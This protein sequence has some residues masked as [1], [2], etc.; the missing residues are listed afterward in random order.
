MNKIYGIDVSHHQGIVDWD[1]VSEWLKSKNNHQNS[2]FAILRVGYSRRD[3][4]GGLVT[5]GQIL[6][7]LSE[8]SRLSIPIGV[9]VYCYDTSPEAA[10]TTMAQALK[11][12]E[13]YKLQYPVVY[14]VEYGTNDGKAYKS[15]SNY[16]YNLTSNKVN[17]TAIIKAAM[18]T[19]ENS[20]YYGMVYCSRNFFTSYTDLSALSAYDKWEAAYTEKDTD[21]VENGIWQYTSSGVVD[22]ISGNVDLDVAYKDYPGIIQPSA[23]KNDVPQ[24]SQVDNTMIFYGRNQ[25]PFLYSRYGYTRGGGKTWHGGIDIVGLDSNIVRMPWY[26]YDNGEAKS[27]SGTVTRSRIVTDK[28][29]KTWEWG[30]YVCVQLD[31][32]QTPDAVNFMYFAHNDSLL[33]KVGDKVK[34]GDALAIMGNSGNAALND[35]PYKHVHFAVRATATGKDLDPSRY[36]GVENAVGIYGEPVGDTVTE[37]VNQADWNADSYIISATGSD[38]EELRSLVERLKLPCTPVSQ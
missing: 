1:R 30:Y 3:G 37:N 27:I 38:K 26:H 24:K 16:Q 5:D 29:N 2:G 13:E 14:D 20:G 11:T 25:I 33:V 6:R 7:N 35:P 12:I 32:N 17:N 9:Y 18:E 21:A 36:H 8:C 23:E 15:E 34:S 4:K 28:S 22:G 31:A 19:V 10:R